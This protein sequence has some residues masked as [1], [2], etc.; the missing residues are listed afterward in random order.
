MSLYAEVLKRTIIGVHPLAVGDVFEV[1][2]GAEVDLLPLVSVGVIAVHS[3][4]TPTIDSD[5][6][7]AATALAALET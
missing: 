2:S 4:A 7:T 1:A 5:D 3:S 6:A